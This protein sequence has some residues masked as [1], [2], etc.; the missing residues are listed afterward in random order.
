MKEMHSP[1]FNTVTTPFAYRRIRN[2]LQ[3]NMLIFVN[4]TTGH[5]G[6][7]LDLRGIVALT[8]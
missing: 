1:D 4:F 5:K 8:N 3:K 6:N 2:F 7:I